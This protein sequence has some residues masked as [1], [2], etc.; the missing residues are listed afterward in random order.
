MSALDVDK[1]REDFP[2]LQRRINKKPILYLD[3]ACMTLK[4]RQVIKAMQDYYYNFPAC[5]DRSSH[6]LS[7]EVSEACEEARDKIQKFFNAK[8][9]EEIIFTRNTTE[10]VNLVARGLDLKEGD[11]V[12]T[13]DKEHNS[14]LIPWLRLKK[15][16][17]II[18]KVV[19]SNSDNTFNLDAFEKLINPRVKLVSMV[20]TSNID[21]YTLP[22]KKIIEI[23]H[24][25]GSLVLLDGAQS[26]PQIPIDVQE[27]DVDFFACSLH[28]MLGPTGVGILYGKYELLQKLSPLN[29][30]GDTVS[31]STYLSFSLLPPPAKFEAGLQDYAGIIG[32]GAAIDYLNSVGI[33]NIKAHEIRLN[34]I[35]TEGIKD[36]PGIRIIGPSD[37]V[38]RGGIV[39]FTFD[40]LGA[41]DLAMILD[42]TANIMVRAGRHCV[43]SWYHSRR[44]KESV[45][46]SLYIYNTAWEAEFFVHHLLTILKKFIKNQAQKRIFCRS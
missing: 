4:P 2:S 33:E 45:R 13:T 43:H 46:A 29:L 20:H 35:I 12:L 11:T 26:A 24:Q 6:K 22:A 3:S 16:R 15:K 44:I 19:K 34:K 21:G 25:N 28:K 8:R 37:P 18:H 38:L 7:V 30:G 14:N 1:I 36:F 5:T 41:Q 17:G 31:D 32:A 9:Y 27:L 40:T 10:A 42:E 23:A 39:N